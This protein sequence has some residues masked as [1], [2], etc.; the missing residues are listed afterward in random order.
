MRRSEGAWALIRRWDGKRTRILTQWN[1]N[2][3]ALHL[4]GGHR[5]PGESFRACLLREVGEELGLSA[6]DFTA[7]DMTLTRM[8]Y[9]A[10]S[11]GALEE[12]EYVLE[13][14]MVELTGAAADRVSADAANAWLT[15]EEAYSSRATD[16]RRVSP[17]LARVLTQ[18][19]GVAEWRPGPERKMS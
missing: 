4:V 9:T 1:K 10:W 18:L 5:R 12:T 7:G 17:T 2:W 11:E 15:A 8:E 14:F 16:G 19:P 13:V 3:Q 6:D